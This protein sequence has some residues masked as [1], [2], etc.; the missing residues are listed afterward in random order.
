MRRLAPEIR[1]EITLQQ[2][3]FVLSHRLKLVPDGNGRLTAVHVDGSA[4]KNS[5]PTEPVE[6]LCLPPSIQRIP[7]TQALIF[8]KPNTIYDHTGDIPDRV[9][10]S[11][12][13]KVFE[14][15]TTSRLQP[16]GH[17][18]APLG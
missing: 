5:L 1:G 9:H 8:P 2:F 11:G 16:G 13:E 12:Q 10:T 6:K 3:G 4:F 18:A 17:E 14:P 7:A 15:I